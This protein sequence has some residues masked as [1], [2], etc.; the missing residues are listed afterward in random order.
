MHIWK[1][2]KD[3][4]PHCCLKISY[5]SATLQG[6]VGGDSSLSSQFSCSYYSSSQ[7]SH[8]RGV[9]NKLAPFP[10]T[11]EWQINWHRFPLQGSDKKTGTVSH[12]REVTW[13]I[14]W[15][16]FPL[17]GQVKETG[18][19]PHYR[20]HNFVSS[21]SPFK[22]ISIKASFPIT[23][24][25]FVWHK[26]SISTRQTMPNNNVKVNWF[27][28]TYFQVF[29]NLCLNSNNSSSNYAVE[30]GSNWS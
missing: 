22:S 14:N 16:P 8:Y 13:Q 24:D 6:W 1:Y 15:H 3:A 7:T 17:Q 29:S 20:G 25:S 19:L 27:E 10:I 4:I 23:E 18:T 9:T 5:N 11:R 2:G 26:S 30:R 12:Y 21:T 28:S